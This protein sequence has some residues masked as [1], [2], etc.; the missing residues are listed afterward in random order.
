MN[1]DW[2]QENQAKKKIQV[3]QIVNLLRGEGEIFT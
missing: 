2:L 3:R 1:K